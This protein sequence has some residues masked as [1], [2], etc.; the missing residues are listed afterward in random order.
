LQPP[1]ADVPNMGIMV[2]H[3][4]LAEINQQLRDCVASDSG[5]SRTGANAVSFDQRGHHP[6]SLGLRNRVHIEHY[7]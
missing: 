2:L 6:N 5:H 3:A 4:R 7:A 1:N